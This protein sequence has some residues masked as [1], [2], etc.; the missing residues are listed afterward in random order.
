MIIGAQLF[1]VR[2]KCQNGDDLRS[3]FKA[4]KEMGYESIQ[5]SGF[6][7]DAKEV[8]SIA[9]EF[10]LHIGLTHTAPDDII[11][12]TDEV[13]EKHK[14]LGADVV[15]VGGA[16]GIYVDKETGRIK[17]ED[18]MR[19]M[20]PAVE[21]LEAAGLKFA[22]HNHF[23]EFQ[24]YGGWNIMDLL[25]EKT[26]WL[27]T[28]DTG[29]AHYAGADVLALIEKYKD[30]LAYVHLKDFRKAETEGEN[31]SNLIAPL[32]SGAV[33]VDEII[34]KLIEVGTVKV[35]YVEQDNASAAEDP[36]AE[37]KKSID[38]LKAH[39]WVK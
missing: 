24:D 30:R 12:K 4:L 27:F 16:F 22:F 15:G 33:P 10:G 9:D 13:I 2:V 7:Y 39:G 32:Y 18:F 3:T 31:P 6:P 36:I 19:D 35:A 5:V 14:I 20:A 25:F 29:W 8:R 37:M 26:N 38:G 23:K 1:S 17:I 11:N 28:F 21:K 34:A